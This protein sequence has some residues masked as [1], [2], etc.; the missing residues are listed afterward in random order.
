MTFNKENILQKLLPGKGSPGISIILTG[1]EG[2][3]KSSLLMELRNDLLQ[4]GASILFSNG[5][6]GN[7][8]PYGVIYT[9][10]KE[11]RERI[12]GISIP[13]IILSGIEME[14]DIS[15]DRFRALEN[16]L[17]DIKNINKEFSPLVVMIDDLEYADLGSQEFISYLTRAMSDLSVS[18]IGTVESFTNVSSDIKELV[19]NHVI[20]SVKIEPYTIN[21]LDNIL[22]K[23]GITLSEELLNEANGNPLK[24]I[25]LLNRNQYRIDGL[26]KTE[27]EILKV[28]YLYGGRIKVMLLMDVISG[29]EDEIVDSIDNLVSKN[30]IYEDTSD[31]ISYSH[32]M[33]MNDIGK[34]IT[35]NEKKEYS[36]KLINSIK[37]IHG[38]KMEAYANILSKLSENIGIYTDAYIYG[39]EHM[40]HLLKGYAIEDAIKEGTRLTE[41]YKNRG[42]EKDS[43]CLK[44]AIDLYIKLGEMNYGMGN[45]SDGENCLK[46]ALNMAERSRAVDKELYIHIRMGRVHFNEGDYGVALNEYEKALSMIGNGNEKYEAQINNYIGH[47]Y[48]MEGKY[49]RA[50]EYFKKAE[51]IA[52]SNGIDEEIAHAIHRIGT[53]QFNTGDMDKAEAAL[54]KAEHIRGNLG[55]LKEQGYSLNNL[56]IVENL[57]GNY[58]KSMEYY[59][60]AKTIAERISDM[61]SIIT[62]NTNIGDVYT[63]FGDFDKAEKM[64]IEN[65]ELATKINDAYTKALSYFNLADVYR[66]RELYD[67]AKEYIIRTL[68]VVKEHNITQILPDVYSTFA[69]IE[70]KRN[71]YV[72]AMSYI[73]L[74]YESNSTS[75]SNKISLAALKR[76]ESLYNQY[77]GNYEVA[78]KLVQ[79]SIDLTIS[80][81]LKFT[82][83]QLYDQ[84]GDL[85]CLMN[86]Q[87]EGLNYYTESRRLY[88]E[89]GNRYR[90]EIENKKIMKLTGKENNR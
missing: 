44:D 80:I 59:K 40:Q 65:M 25:K 74:G 15:S 3:G 52:K 88:D 69:E 48:E 56:G 31:Y 6:V 12:G 67:K 28:T 26:S 64:F 23:K 51:S 20:E 30:I 45:I 16:I 58:E 79:E 68:E 11:F 9:S 66:Y 5:K 81:S 41:L 90:F 57:R 43:R 36:M 55:L 17:H 73:K 42:L 87:K 34:V 22:R 75:L 60:K 50:L 39:R 4:K 37:K 89:M 29:S 2:L 21:E 71:N 49:V 19:R 63:E 14:P 13:P 77:M 83:P 72:E 38:R 10:I 24:A 85:L 54:K 84:Y 32:Q 86:R 61:N 78:E 8:T 33:D 53:V 27:K 70:I 7:N 76:V 1:E 46:I 18:F 35:D 47:I 62:V 82:L